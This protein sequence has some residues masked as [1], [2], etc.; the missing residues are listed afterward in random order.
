MDGSTLIRGGDGD[1]T[2]NIAMT[3]PFT[4]TQIDAGGGDDRAFL[5]LPG[6]PAEGTTSVA[7]QGGLTIGGGA[8]RNVFSAD[9]PGNL[10]CAARGRRLR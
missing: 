6:L 8:G 9:I 7:V 5:G 1:D 4:Y 3:D 2:F 10:Q